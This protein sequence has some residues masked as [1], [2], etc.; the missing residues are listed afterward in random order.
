MERVIKRDF[1]ERGKSKSLAKKDFLK[2]WELFYKDKK[3]NNSRNYLKKI[4]FTN[5]R[6]I[7]YLIKKLTNI[8]N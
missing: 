5:K 4:I 2:A 3:K 8:E 1:L 7:N 6:D